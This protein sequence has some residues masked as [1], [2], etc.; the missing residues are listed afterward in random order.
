MSK[1]N[2]VAQVCMFNE[3]EKGNLDRCLDNLRR[4]C[5]RIVIYDDA[6]T[7]DSVA[8]AERYGAHVIRGQVNNQMQELAHKQAILEKSLEFGATH[9]FWLDCDEVLDRTGTMGGLRDLCRDWPEGVD[10]FSF[11]EINLWRSQTWQRL[12]SL[13]TKARFVRLWKV[14]PE[15]SFNV[16]EGV[17]KQLYPAT[18][19]NVQEAP[20]GVIHYGF[21]DYKKMMVKIGAHQMDRD[22]LHRCAE[23]GIDG[24]GANWIL[25]ERRCACRKLPDSIFP[26]GCLPPDIKKRPLPRPIAALKTYDRIDDA[27]PPPLVDR[28]ALVEWTRLHQ[29]GYHGLYNKILERNWRVKNDTPI[30]P[31]NRAS[32]FKFNPA[33]K[34]VVDLACGG[35]W[36]MLDCLINGAQKVIGVEINDALIEQ[37]RR[38]FRELAIPETSY[39]F[40]NI[41]DLPPDFPRVDLV[42][43]VAMFMHIPFWQAVRY[44]QWIHEAL[45][46]GGEAHLQFHQVDGAGMTMFWDGT[47]EGKGDSVSTIRLD[48]ELERAGLIIKEK[49][50]AEGA[51]VL[52]VWQLYRCV[53]EAS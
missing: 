15:I 39:E 31:W 46:P 33:G 27:P 26:P 51:G 21:H 8:V 14:T 5:D 3:V 28:R 17:H 7:D 44:F 23:F 53:K 16:R 52:P 25:D 20:F 49:R 12:D 34:V 22:A 2:L 9:L 4:Y 30:D 45:I 1:V 10:A 19:Q 47:T 6:S 37:A 35:G 18:I 42:Y 13:F 29:G 38:S 11:P 43:C 32:L 50:L 36:F 40:L 41:A 24:Q 48:H